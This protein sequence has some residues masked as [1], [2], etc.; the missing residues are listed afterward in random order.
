MRAFVTGLLGSNLIRALRWEGYKVKTLVRSM[1][2]SRR[3]LNDS[4]IGYVVGDM[5]DVDGWAKELHECDVVFH[6]AASRN[7]DLHETM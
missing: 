2:Q 7:R 4:G 1:E 5:R 3:V 6:T